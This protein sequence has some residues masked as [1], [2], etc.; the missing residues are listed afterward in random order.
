MTIPLQSPDRTD[1]PCYGWFHPRGSKSFCQAWSKLKEQ[2][3]IM[4]KSPY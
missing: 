2:Q 3:I 1:I 4:K